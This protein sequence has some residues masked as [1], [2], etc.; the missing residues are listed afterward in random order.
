MTKKI[1]I[2]KFL[3]DHLPMDATIKE[4]AEMLDRPPKQ[5]RGAMD[6]FGYIA[7][8][9]F[10]YERTPVDWSSIDWSQNNKKIAAQVDRTEKYV[11]DRRKRFA[12]PEHRF[13]QFDWS[14]VDWSK[15]NH[16]IAEETGQKI[17]NVRNM[18][19]Y[20]APDEYKSNITNWQKVDWSLSNQ[21]IA[22]QLDKNVEYVR[23]MRHQNAPFHLRRSRRRG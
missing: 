9:D 10:A 6:Q 17:A 11:A 20:H 15:K 7:G 4:I 23:R 3:E 16:V 19:S 21:E 22:A 14:A 18:R 1:S 13:T 5:I 2:K 12:P 8:L